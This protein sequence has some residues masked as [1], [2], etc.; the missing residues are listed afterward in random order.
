MRNFSEEILQDKDRL[1]KVYV[2]GDKNEDKKGQRVQ[3]EERGRYNRK[4][5]RNR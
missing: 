1:L 5:N 3:G 2:V 4:I